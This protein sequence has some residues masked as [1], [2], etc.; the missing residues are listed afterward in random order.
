M[1]Q[2]TCSIKSLSHW[3]LNYVLC[4]NM[5]TVS[6]L[7]ESK[8]N[9]IS[10]VHTSCIYTLQLNKY[11]SH[12]NT[13]FNSHLYAV[14]AEVE[15]I[16][17]LEALMHLTNTALVC[18]VIECRRCHWWLYVRIKHLIRRLFAAAIFS[19]VMDF[20]IQLYSLSPPLQLQKR[21][22]TAR[23]SVKHN[24]FCIV[25]HGCGPIL[26]FVQLYSATVRPC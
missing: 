23:N 21:W 12:L 5:H 1:R 17:Q 6:L 2:R 20:I 19:I 3:V 11:H 10:A 18:N 22:D 16:T 4:K 25:E 13:G 8:H 14:S 7:I 24:V 26:S 15:S 9:F